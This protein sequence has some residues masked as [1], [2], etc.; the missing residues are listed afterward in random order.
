MNKKFEESYVLASD[1][2][3]KEKCLST[4]VGGSNDYYFYNTIHL[5]NVDP[6]LKVADNKSKF[7]KLVKEWSATSTPST[8]RSNLNLVELRQ[9]ILEFSESEAE[10]MKSSFD[11]LVQKLK[12]LLGLTFTYTATHV[13]QDSGS[14][15][16]PETEA[17]S[18]ASILSASLI[19]TTVIVKDILT[20][21]SPSA[22]DRIET[23]ALPY[24]LENF[25]IPENMHKNIL[26]RVKYPSEKVIELIIKNPTSFGT[27]PIHRQLTIEQMERVAKS[28]PSFVDAEYVRTYLLKILLNKD[29]NDWMTI[30][31]AQQE[32]YQQAIKFVS[33]LSNSL[34][35]FKLH[36]YY[37]YIS[38]L[39]SQNQIA[40]NQD[41]IDKY[42]QLPR[43]TYFY[44]E[45]TISLCRIKNEISSYHQNIHEFLPP[46][47][48]DMDEKMIKNLLKLIFIKESEN[49]IKKYLEYFRPSFLEPILA[50]IKLLF[51]TTEQDKWS[52]LL[53]PDQ[54]KQIESRVDI[55]F[56]PTNPIYYHPDDS[57]DIKCAIKNVPF[58]MVKLF[59]I[60]TFN[61]YKSNKSAINSNINLDG[62]VA[63]QEFT[64]NYSNSPISKHVETFNFPSLQ[65]KR[66]VFVLEF[67]G[68]GKSSRAIIR[69]GELHII[70]STGPLGQVVQ[71]VDEESVKILKSSIYI[72]NNT[73]KSN[74]DGDIIIPFTNGASTKSIIVMTQD[75]ATLKDF[76]HQSESYS[77][78]GGIF[79]D[80]GSLIQ[81]EKAPIVVRAK[82]FLGSTQISAS[83]LEEPTLTI[84]STD[85]SPT[86]IVNSK[87]VK[88]FTISDKQESVFLYKVLENLK[89]LRVTF[90]A[91]VRAVS[92]GNK[93]ETLSFSQTFTVNSIN[94]TANFTDLFFRATANDGYKMYNLGKGG[95]PIPNAYITL[96]FKHRL[97]TNSVY[98]NCITDKNGM[99][100]LGNL[101]NIDSVE[102]NCSNSNRYAFKLY[103]KGDYTY[104]SNI[105]CKLNQVI[106]LPYLSSNQPT[107]LDVALYEMADTLIKKDAYDCIAFENNQLNIVT[108]NAGQ[109]KLV[110]L[111][112]PFVEINIDVCDGDIRENNIVGPCRIL[113]FSE[114]LIKGLH[115]QTSVDK[116]HIKI[117]LNNYTES[118]RVH[119]LASW[120]I[121]SPG[122]CL[123]ERL[124]LDN[125][126]LD[127]SEY[128]TKI[129][130]EF[131]S[132][133]EL[134][135]E[136]N[137]ILNRKNAKS[138]LPGNSLKKPSLLIQPWS[139][140]Q[141]N[142]SKDTL[143]SSDNYGESEKRAKS[144]NISKAAKKLAS[145][146]ASHYSPFLE[147]LEQPTSVLY[148]LV[149]DKDGV[150]TLPL[151]A[152]SG[153][154]VSIVAI[155]NESMYSNHVLLDMDI[156]FKDTKL[157]SSLD[158]SKHYK[159][160]KLITTV[161]P[162]Q[163][164]EIVNVASSKYTVYDTLDKALSLLKTI[165]GEQFNLKEFSFIGD[166]ST[167]TLEQKKEKFSK[168]TCH[169]LNF[170]IY[171]K[172]KEFFEQVVLPVVKSKAYKTF[173]DYYLIGD[174]AKLGEFLHCAPKYKQLN[175]L[176]KILLAQHFPKESESI[177]NLIRQRTLFNPIKSI[178]YDSL[179]KVALN[180][181]DSD[182]NDGINL[183]KDGHDDEFNDDDACV[184]QS[185][186]SHQAKEKMLDECASFSFGGAPS[187]LM[188][189]ASACP[190]PPPS[191]CDAF[192]GPPPP[193]ASAAP[194]MMMRMAAPITPAPGAMNRAREA[195]V[196]YQKIE[197]TEE[198]AETHYYKL[199][200]P[201]ASN[202]PENEFWAD[203]AEFIANGKKSSSFLSKYI[204][205]TT[206]SL[207]ES[208]MALAVLD[209]PFQTKGDNSTQV[210]PKNGKLS[211][212]PS[213]PIIVYHQELVNADIDTSKSSSSGILISQHF[214]DPNNRYSY[215]ANEQN[216]I[217]VT[218]QFLVSKV[219]GALIV[220]ANLSSKQKKLDILLQIPKGAI[221]VGPSPFYTKDH[222]IELYS[223]SNN[224]I[225]YYFY[226]PSAGNFS[227]FP[228]HV[229]EKNL[230]IASVEPFRFN[231]VVKPTIVNHLSWE[232]IANHGSADEILDYLGKEN[233][234]RINFTHVYHRFTDK[235]LW[236]R[237][238]ELLKSKK[239][240]EPET[241]S[242]AL[243]H[244]NFKFMSD[245][246]PHRA[247]SLS[248]GPSIYSQLL[249]VDPLLNGT[250]KHLE[251][252]PLVNSRT[253]QLGGERKIL[254]E[255]F[256][257]Q[258]QKICN[259][260]LFKLNPTD[261]ELLSLTYYLLLQDRFEESIEIMKR[262]GGANSNI[263]N[264]VNNN[265]NNNN[266][267]SITPTSL[268][269]TITQAFSHS[270]YTEDLS[271]EEK[272]KKKEEEK[273]K[274]QEDKQREKE[275]KKKKKEEEKKKKEED[276]LAKKLSKKGVDTSAANTTTTTTA[277]SPSSEPQSSEPISPVVLSEDE[278]HTADE[279]VDEHSEDEDEHTDDENSIIQISSFKKPSCLPELQIQYDYLISYL[280]FF[281]P[282]PIHAKQISKKYENYPVSRW[283]SLFKDLK[284]K[285]DQ[286]DDN[287]SI[288]IDHDNEI[289][290]ERRQAK[291]AS[292]EPTFDVSLDS[293]KTISINY[294]NL[295]DITVNYYIMD[296]ELLFSTNPF[297]QQELGQ[298]LYVAPNKKESFPLSTRNGTF[299]IPIPKEFHNSNIVVDCEASQIHRNLTIYSNNLAVHITEKVGQLRV[300]DKQTKKPI[301]KTYIKVY[302]KTDK[303]EFWKDGYT[304]IAGYFDYATVSSGNISNVSKLS[305]LVM[306][307]QFG[308]V[309][310][311]AKPP[312]I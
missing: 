244:R 44:K 205:F 257:A 292:N 37:H 123:Q 36:I 134:G 48:N 252:Y 109:F 119:V 20:S 172:D 305:I 113:A 312:G 12:S 130:S 9:K 127:Y 115:F 237:V 171:H 254:N 178:N 165:V 216:E 245:Y 296:I 264:D 309:I 2:A 307:N 229:S 26:Y 303:V 202:I 184:T 301:S 180:Q 57:V 52:R 262:I 73:F 225:E 275:E 214:F 227:H 251:Y 83:Y 302:A 271:K 16:A 11:D 195:S 89:E 250:T 235:A 50:E 46:V 148:N 269:S 167:M 169:E 232:Y 103:N 295:S 15:D 288:E 290:R 97:F 266:Q 111:N 6:Q 96:Q 233:L 33:S 272:K 222:S 147:F 289:D 200:N 19:D 246:L 168:Y 32:F 54:V 93:Q 78:S 186:N 126:S 213:S 281:N 204:A 306:S 141:T 152:L 137:Y 118:T 243:Y 203:Y 42:F 45:E 183:E 278:H 21:Y 88:P 67:I 65:G 164:F 248:F 112:W 43:D 283:N 162:N 310:K 87:E 199:L 106:S 38:F 86:P 64:F 144:K 27:Y 194:R 174:V 215:E 192:A 59:E 108:K 299:T 107:R 249:T 181:L 95:E 71:V 47:T 224:I 131:F 74:Q 69:K 91:K 304:D 241:W 110:L 201:T 300:V 81:G 49:D 187:P 265:N 101:E 280:D 135:D 185:F 98:T 267:S 282:N 116:N 84:V 22:V 41:I 28:Y 39:I 114:P 3:E 51:S 286:I 297:V 253:H 29:L 10:T 170:F 231:V 157:T 298:F 138:T 193:M 85:N 150:I 1:L 31:S 145:S 240:F 239:F 102:A 90:E 236:L 155:D 156:K 121:I 14:S 228:T 175:C 146:V 219:Y 35:S 270:K 7:D 230:I 238:I 149:P 76:E 154:H 276:K 136:I 198:Y 274:K 13:N 62:L 122:N 258:Y 70:S 55:D 77:L 261:S 182:I 61:Y 66:G 291:M 163:S 40:E 25:T 206:N 161:Q 24:V 124:L 92:R 311:E 263:I 80:K 242:F 210:R 273:K 285:I 188:A 173:I 151:S 34:N 53:R 207:S 104:P 226:F 284:N 125:S 209:L 212:S 159:Q 189:M 18:A 100:H 17:K 142:S 4:L 120:F 260:L 129:K 72:D 128:S 279:D 158:A 176:E 79:I 294:S 221:P 82:L 99:V 234:Y 30:K 75:F 58:L 140:S 105:H 153:S 8:S 197:K 256:S 255:K 190:P 177:A 277:V 117:Q 217:Y 132:G 293:N 268:L 196:L 133:R 143:K 166:W 160:D 308:A 208:I 211:M 23:A 191:A 5:L 247:T 259:L 179:F 220:V 223:Y 139:I 94:S 287:D 60:N 63:S 218:D 68:N 56:E